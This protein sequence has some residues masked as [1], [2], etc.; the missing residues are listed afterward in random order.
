MS[1]WNSTPK[2]HRAP[3]SS[4]AGGGVVESASV[5]WQAGGSDTLG[6][7]DRLTQLH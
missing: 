7:S 3:A 2:V 5:G 1:K 6:E 4:P